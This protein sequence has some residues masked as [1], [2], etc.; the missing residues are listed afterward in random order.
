METTR[1]VPDFL[2][3]AWRSYLSFNER[4]KMVFWASFGNLIGSTY[5]YQA[6]QERKQY[7]TSDHLEVSLYKVE[8][9]DIRKFENTWNSYSR[10]SQT[11]LG[12]EWTKMYKAI[13]WDYTPFSFVSMRMWGRRKHA[14]AF[15]A[16]NDAQSAHSEICPVFRGRFVSVVDDSVVRLIG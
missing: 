8:K 16:S 15:D 4:E 3:K 5:G 9:D 14:E 11:H 6:N 1:F 7:K 13:A 12:Y 10:L 2:V